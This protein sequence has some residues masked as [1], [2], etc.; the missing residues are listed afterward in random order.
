MLIK[1]NIVSIIFEKLQI[2]LEVLEKIMYAVTPKLKP[3]ENKYY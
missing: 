3:Y 1:C 2:L